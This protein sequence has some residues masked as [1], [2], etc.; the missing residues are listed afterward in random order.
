VEGAVHFRFLSRDRRAARP[1]ETRITIYRPASVRLSQFAMKRP[2]PDCVMALAQARERFDDETMFFDVFRSDSGESILCLG[3]P[4]D[5]C[6]PAGLALRLSGPH[7][8]SPLTQR[9]D[10]PRIKLQH[11]SRL[12]VSGPGLDDTLLLAAGETSA[13]IAVNQSHAALL[14]G[15]RVVTTL[16]RDNPL[17]WIR[18]WAV[19]Y[20]RLHGADAVLLYD[21]GSK[22]YTLEEIAAA[23]SGI[24]GLRDVVIVSWPFPYG[25]GV[26][27]EPRAPSVDNFCQTGSLDHARRCFCPQARS[28]LNVDIDEL[29]PP[30]K[31][32]IF[33]KV[34]ES[35]HAVLLFHGVWAE[36]P[37]I[38]SAEALRRVRH[39]DCRS[40]WQSQIDML[41]LRK[42]ETLCRTKWV[43]VPSR[44]HPDVE[45]GVHDIYP[46]TDNAHETQR[47]WRKRDRSMAYRHC[48]QINVGWKTDRWRSSVDFNSVC[49]P[50]QEMAIAFSRAFGD[51]TA[52]P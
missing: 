12:T 32:T 43:A 39:R 42:T 31:R 40:V 2:M 41:A 46:A 25:L 22:D 50:D 16:S 19:F 11:T 15:R 26:G 14:A 51:A 6:H 48:R 49:S 30:R 45:W 23:L 38:D 27:L 44:C 7:N 9:L 18:D 4:L 8:L 17:P 20:V 10:A 29:L 3:P 24:A 13:S 33:E 52:A 1:A 35:P 47:S 21:N 36:A 5:G 37:G 28:V 34:E